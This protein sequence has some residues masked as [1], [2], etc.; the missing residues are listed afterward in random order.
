MSADDLDP[1]YDPRAWETYRRDAGCGCTNPT[2]VK[3]KVPHGTGAWLC[4]CHRLS[5]PIDQDAVPGQPL[6][7][8]QKHFQE[9][10]QCTSTD[11]M[12]RCE[13]PR[14]HPGDHRQGRTY[15]KQRPDRATERAEL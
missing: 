2:P 9:P 6:D 5:G 13:R 3:C 11:W 10:N 1:Q 14:G 4:V 12:F 8:I 7:W 15:W